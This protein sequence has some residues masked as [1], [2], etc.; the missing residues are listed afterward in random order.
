MMTENYTYCLVYLNI[1]L[2]IHTYTVSE[3]VYVAVIALICLDLISWISLHFSKSTTPTNS[4]FVRDLN[5]INNDIELPM[6]NNT[7]KQLHT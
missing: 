2:H 3:Y 1:Q 5:V 6:S 4:C 7:K